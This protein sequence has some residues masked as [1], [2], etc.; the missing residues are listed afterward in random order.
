VFH[1]NG[2][3]L[4]YDFVLRPGADPA[5]I[6]IAFEGADRIVVD[7][8]G[9]LELSTPH[10]T[11]T[12]LKPRIWQTTPDGREEVAGRYVLS[13]AAEARFEVDQYDRHATLVIDPVIKYSTYFGSV[14]DDRI[15]AVAIDSTGAT[16][17][18]GSTATGAVSW[19]FV[20]KMNPGG[21]AVVYTVFFGAQVL[22]DKMENMNFF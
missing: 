21:T 4:E 3:H 20:S 14:R 17:V 7:A 1:G 2:E 5:Q 12:Q 15:Q 16:Y 6:R 11:L 19:G 9:N 8:Q 10:G 18:A 13:G 22:I